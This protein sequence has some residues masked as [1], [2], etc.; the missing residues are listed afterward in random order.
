MKN[1]IFP[2]AIRRVKSFSR[3]GNPIG[4]EKIRGP[5]PGWR[6]Y[7]NTFP[8]GFSRGLG[9]SLCLALVRPQNPKGSFDLFFTFEKPGKR[10]G[11]NIFPLNVNYSNFP[12]FF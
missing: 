1:K 11:R 9:L 4:G 5:L 2:L 7:R 3:K 10:S 6:L 12:E 8:C